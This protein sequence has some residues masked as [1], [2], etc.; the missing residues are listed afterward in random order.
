M[1]AIGHCPKC[2]EHKQPHRV[3]AACGYYA[4]TLVIEKPEECEI[5]IHEFAHTAKSC[6]HCLFGDSLCE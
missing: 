2:G 5:R 4:D 1:P 3:C 6:V